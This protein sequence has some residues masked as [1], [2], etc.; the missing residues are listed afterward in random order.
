MGIADDGDS[1]LWEQAL[2]EQALWEQVTARRKALGT[3]DAH[4]LTLTAVYDDLDEP[5]CGSRLTWAPG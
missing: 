2:W 3:L 1:A 5:T 4:A